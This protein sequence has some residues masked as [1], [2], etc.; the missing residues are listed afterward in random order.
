M[1]Y[2]VTVFNIC[3]L[4]FLFVGRSFVVNYLPSEKGGRMLFFHRILNSGCLT[5][6]EIGIR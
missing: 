1:Y 5:D 4:D 2:F 3:G 6:S